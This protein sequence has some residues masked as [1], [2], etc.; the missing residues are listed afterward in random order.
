MRIDPRYF[1]PTEVD[2]LLGDASKARRSSA[3]GPRSASSSSCAR[4]SRRTARWPE[5]DALVAREGYSRR[6]SRANE[7]RRQ[8]SS[9]RATAASRA[10]RSC[11][12]CA[13][14][15]YTNLVSAAASDARSARCRRRGAILRGATARIRVHG[16]RQGRRHPGQRHYPA[17]FIRDNLL[18][19][20]NVI[21]AA[22]RHGDA[23]LCSWAR[24]ASTRGSRRSRC[25]RILLLTGPLE[26][27]NQWYAIAKIAGHQDVRGVRPPVWLQRDLRDADQPLR[28]RRQLRPRRPR[29]CC[30]R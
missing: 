30:P 28:P 26:P 5:R 15:G 23:K 1:R 2:T 9:S 29:T 27:T 6:Q 21:D 19:Q 7:P 22:Y 13:R 20:T 24:A 4:W 25:A 8:P 17:D 12:R 14:A 16:R 11:A 3:G 18:I 10:P